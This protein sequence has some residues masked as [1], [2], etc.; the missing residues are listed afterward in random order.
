MDYT[1]H[2]IAIGDKI[3]T[4][5]IKDFDADIDA[6]STLQIDY[7]NIIGDII[8]FPV[9][10]N[11]LSLLR[12]DMESIV[13]TSKLEMS[14]FEAKTAERVRVKMSTMFAGEGKTG[15]FAKPTKDEV[16]NAV[17]TDPAFIQV[18]RDHISRIRDAAIVDGLYWAAKSKDGKLNAISMKMKPEEFSDQILEGTINDV[19]IRIKN[20]PIHR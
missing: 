12:A 19:L 6:E 4:I 11:R 10:F 7:N 8:T 15:R 20:A 3:V 2:Q 1:R 9:I 5:Q 14:I 13:A 17:A 18:Q 16:D